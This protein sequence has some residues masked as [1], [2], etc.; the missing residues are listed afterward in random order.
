MGLGFD[1]RTPFIL[2][3]LVKSGTGPIDVRLLHFDEG[4]DSVSQKYAT[5]TAANDAAV[6]TL[7]GAVGGRI[8]DIHV[9]MIEED[10]RV[11][12]R[13]VGALATDVGF[14]GYSDVVV[15]I[16]GLP[17][18]LYFP[19][20]RTFLRNVDAS[21]AGANNETTNLHVTLSESPTFDASVREQLT[22][23][24]EFLPGFL[25]TAELEQDE[26]MPRVWAPVLGEQQEEALKLIEQKV[27]VLDNVPEI[28]PVLPFPALDP[29]RGDRLLLEYRGLFESWRV[30]HRNII[31]ASEHNPFDV[32]RQLCAL[33]D[34][35][36]RALQPLRG[37]K[38]IISAHSSK[39]LSLGAL[40]A[41][42]DRP[43]VAVAYVEAQGYQIDGPLTAP[44]DAVP[45]EIWIAGEPYN[46][47]DN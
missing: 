6:R 32:Y 31:Y 45:Y 26:D 36:C 4:P 27:R 3:I 46:A 41:A 28:C 13:R 21:R 1:P 15:D 38:M 39:L 43:E 10:R 35:Y 29:K 20:L 9:P 34:R 42:C 40:L 19:L 24:A 22:E 23:R 2:D 5:E 33:Y 30:D 37:A 8:T 16:S 47:N 14:L 25:G 12:G 17:R 7:V 11:G 44:A 18:A